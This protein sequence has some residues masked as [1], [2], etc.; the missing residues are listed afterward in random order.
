VSGN[1]KFWNGGTAAAPTW[2]QH[3]VT[4]ASA[5]PGNFAST[6][7]LILGAGYLLSGAATR[8]VLSGKL[9]SAAIYNGVGANT[10]P[11]LGTK[12]FDVNGLFG[13]GPTF[14]SAS[15]HVV[16][17][18]GGVSYS[19]QDKA[20]LDA[21]SVGLVRLVGPCL[22]TPV[23]SA[24][25]ITAPVT[26][27]AASNRM[28][29]AEVWRNATDAQSLIGTASSIGA[30]V[31]S[32]GA[33][34]ATCTMSDASSLVTTMSAAAATTPYV[35]DGWFQISVEWDQ[36]TK[37]LA[38]K[39]RKPGTVLSSDTGWTQIASVGSA[40][41]SGAAATSYTW[42]QSTNPN[43]G[44]RRLYASGAVRANALIITPHDIGRLLPG[45]A[46]FPA[47]SGQT[48]TLARTA[49]ATQSLL[50][51][52]DGVAAFINP[53][54]ATATNLL[55]VANTGAGAFPLAAN[56]DA[57][58]GWVGV[59]GNIPNPASLIAGLVVATDTSQ[60]NLTN[61][62]AMPVNGL[63]NTT[64]KT[65][66]TVASAQ[67]TAAT[68]SPV[69][70]IMTLDRV[71]ATIRVGVYSTMG[72][73][74]ASVTASTSAHVGAVNTTPFQ[75]LKLLPGWTSGFLWR[76]GVGIAP[77]VTSQAVLARQLLT[78]TY[79]P[80]A[81]PRAQRSHA[82]H[83]RRQAEVEH[84]GAI[85]FYNGLRGGGLT[86]CSPSSCCG[87]TLDSSQDKRP[88]PQKHNPTEGPE[89]AL[90][91]FNDEFIAAM[92]GGLNDDDTLICSW[93]V[94]R[95]DRQGLCSLERTVGHPDV[96][97]TATRRRRPRRGG[98][99]SQFG[100]RRPDAAGL[101]QGLAGPP[102]PPHRLGQSGEPWLM[103]GS[104][105]RGR[106]AQGR[107]RLTVPDPS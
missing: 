49:A 48:V 66:T 44:F 29:R 24:N 15:S 45:A 87:T 28:M 53:V 46:T 62:T 42:N 96:A 83:V 51:I 94:R 19:D 10:S 25:T 35:V 93:W 2:V 72:T 59:L 22:W 90:V 6:S 105:C 84:H 81:P 98:C 106:G 73:Q 1:V 74:L 55:T 56:E 61:G 85:Q 63:F 57:V 97:W 16:T 78:T 36:P 4:V 47:T 88:A 26:I 7:P 38:V 95:D 37:T 5:F 75:V 77:S 100:P 80:V 71:A 20:L 99:R 65:L 14:T 13:P 64:G 9:Y 41:N 69:A 91:S 52:P 102:T 86:S 31:T 34:Q 39:L 68:H 18:L 33:V 11:V 101:P 32:T 104:Y 17:K 54:P 58:L 79:R 82:P 76:K 92:C 67:P 60:F 50:I 107:S 103:S 21:T 70:L 89:L 8:E 23:A 40:L 27:E 43:A 3:D 30:N 12:V